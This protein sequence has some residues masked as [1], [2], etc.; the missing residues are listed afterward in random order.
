MPAHRRMYA[1]TQAIAVPTVL[2]L[3]SYSQLTAYQEEDFNVT[4]VYR[5]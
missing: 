1:R 3:C 5:S 2:R 4:L